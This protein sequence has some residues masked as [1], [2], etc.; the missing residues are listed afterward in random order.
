[1]LAWRLCAVAGLATL[2]ASRGFPPIQA[3]G[4]THGAGP[5]IALELVRSP[6]ALAELFGSQPCAGLFQA[7]E[8]RASWW[9]ALAFIPAYAAFPALGA[10]ALRGAGRRLDLAALAILLLAALLDKVEGLILF[11]LGPRWS[12]SS[13]NRIIPA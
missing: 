9:D 11:R 3:C 6:A 5:I 10:W 12:C 2:A 1:V 4:P 8:L 7:A 13:R